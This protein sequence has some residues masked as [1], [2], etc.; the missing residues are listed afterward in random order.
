MRTRRRQKTSSF[1]RIFAVAI[2]CLI[3]TGVL[4]AAFAAFG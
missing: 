1:D 3:V 4:G 2:L